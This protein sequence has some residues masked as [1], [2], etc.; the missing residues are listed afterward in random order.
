MVTLVSHNGSGF[1]IKF[2]LKYI[3]GE[4]QFTP[5]LTTRGSRIILL[6]LY[7]V[8]FIYFLNYM[9]MA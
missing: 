6:E 5:E 7:N 8:R 2:I 1:D 9:P 3:L 4:T